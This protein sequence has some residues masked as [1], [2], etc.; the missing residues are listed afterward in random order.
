MISEGLVGIASCYLHHK[1]VEIR[2]EA[3]LLIGSM[4]TVSRGR[5]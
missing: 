1:L 5:E 2:R 4:M 3:I